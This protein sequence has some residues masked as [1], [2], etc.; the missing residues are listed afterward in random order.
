MTYATVQDLIGRFGEQEMI[1]LTTA[2]GDP[3][4]TV[5]TAKADKALG[6]ASA[7][8]DTYL[9]RRYELP[10]SETP[11][12]LVLCTCVLARYELAQGDGRTPTDQIVNARKEWVRWLEMIAAH[13]ADLAVMPT[14]AAD[15]GASGARIEDRTPAFTS[16]ENGGL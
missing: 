5:V 10:L 2:G 8:V 3:M 4:T 1:R 14:D 11:H 9:R 6:D 7:L 12:E 16:A 15:A 13:K